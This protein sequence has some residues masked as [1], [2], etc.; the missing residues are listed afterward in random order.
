MK[1]RC[2][3]NVVIRLYFFAY[4]FSL[5]IISKLNTLHSIFNKNLFLFLLKKSSCKKNSIS[6]S[7]G[8]N[9]LACAILRDNISIKLM[10]IK[11]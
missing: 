10:N 4:I 11:C 1:I 5:L 9:E 7:M 2:N 6:C 3:E 8:V